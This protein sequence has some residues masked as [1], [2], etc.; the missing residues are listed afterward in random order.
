MQ[1]SDDHELLR[2]FQSGDQSAFNDL[3]RKYQ[4]SVYQ[5]I[6]R[7]VGVHEEA[8]DLSQEV[9]IKAFDTLKDFRRESSLFTWMY[10]IAVNLSLNHLRRKKQRQ[11]F[12]LNTIGLSL[13]SRTPKPDQ[14]VEANETLTLIEQAIE[15]LPTKQ[16]LAFTLRYFQKL[17]HAEIARILERDEGTIK[18]NYHLAIRK[19]QKAVSRGGAL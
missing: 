12:S 3:V 9:F 16:K 8:E 14:Q 15:R 4:Q 11:Y 19:L 1:A 7:L 2:R 5:T 13:S 17:P 18:A 10:R 6:R